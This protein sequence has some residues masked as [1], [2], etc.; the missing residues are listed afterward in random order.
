MATTGLLLL[1]NDTRL[2]AY[3]TDPANAVMRVYVVVVKGNLTQEKL[4]NLAKGIWDEGE[5]LK[6]ARIMLRKASNK[7]SHLIVELTEGKNREIRR[8]FKSLGHEV[9]QLKRVALGCLKLEGINPGQFR[10]LKPEEIK[11]LTG[12]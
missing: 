8:L 10:Y 7:E 12:V 2:S 4:L 6:P 1:T 9:I 3:L 11:A 5:F